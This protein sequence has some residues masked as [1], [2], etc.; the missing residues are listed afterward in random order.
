[1]RQLTRGLVALVLGLSSVA[2]LPAGVATAAPPGCADPTAPL[3]VEE[4]RLPGP[5]PTEILARSGFD[6]FAAAFTPALCA[7]RDPMV[8][9]IAVAAQ[10]RLLWETAVARAQGRVPAGSLPVTDDRPLYW[11][12]LGLT[13]ALRQ[14][15]PAF[16]LSDARR[17]ELIGV[18]ET[19]SRGQDSVRYP[20]RE[21]RVLISGFD[22]FQLDQDIRRSN[23]SGVSALAL[24][25]TVVDTPAGRARIEAAVFPVLWDPFAAG[26][27]ERTF[28]PWLGRVDLATTI[29]QGRPE[30]F[31]VERYN[32][33]W[34]GGYPDNDNV[35][36]TGVA[37]IPAGVPT[38][39]PAPEFVPTTLPHQRIVDTPTGRFPVFDNTSVVEIPAG[40]TEPVTSPGGPTPGSVARAG[41]GGD[42]LSN[43]IAYRV[44]L[45]R[46]ALG[47]DLPAGHLHTPVLQFAPDNRTE[48]TDPVFAA[49]QRD[50]ADQVRAVLAVA[51]GS[52]R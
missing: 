23:P 51:V 5:V 8:A 11:A 45:L 40:Q 1:M 13:T 37:P 33:R 15:T 38:V 12:R 6:R 14:W 31:D 52:L 48:V 29:S 16:E 2:L 46:D 18:L 21:K 36:R 7:V 9:Q 20:G 19:A 35:S 49:N 26:T 27:V 41:G 47:L 25:G 22:P 42:Y 50:I 44:T 10:G 3:T 4:R 24:D 30:R 17:A 34:R 28:L 32:G 43:E 39:T